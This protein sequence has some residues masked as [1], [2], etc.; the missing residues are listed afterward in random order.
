MIMNRILILDNSLNHDVYNPLEHWNPLLLFPSDSFRAS[1]GELPPSLNAYSHIIVTGSEASI[2]DNCE[3]MVAEEKLLRI[4]VTMGKVI[5]GSCFGHQIIARSVF[6]PNA[7]RRMEEPEFGW[8]EIEV[9]KND[10]LLGQSGQ[11]IHSFVCHFDEVYD[12]P[13]DEATVL[14]RSPRCS[15]HAFKLRDGSVWGIQPHPEMGIVGGLAFLERIGGSEVPD[16]EYFLQTTQAL[17]K[18][19]GWIVPLMREFQKTRPGE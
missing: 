5:L 9:L 6:G 19:S 16:R 8:L 12:L 17:P 18:D 11:I 10:P 3:W 4:A 13:K 2:L 7:V 15:I 1:A 14:A